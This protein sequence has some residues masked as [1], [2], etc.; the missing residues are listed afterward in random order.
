MI[1]LLMIFSPISQR[2]LNTSRKFSNVGGNQ[3]VYA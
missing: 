3:I 2:G 1:A